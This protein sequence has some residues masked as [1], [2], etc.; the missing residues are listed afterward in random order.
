MRTKLV[1]GGGAASTNFGER[2]N[3][4]LEELGAARIIDIKF[5]FAAYPDRLTTNPCRQYAALILYEPGDASS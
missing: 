1:S 4:A 2:V 3:L 5:S